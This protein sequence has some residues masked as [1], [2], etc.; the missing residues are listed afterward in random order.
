LK[1]TEAHKRGK[2]G[3]GF[4]PEKDLVHTTTEL[5][6][7]NRKRDIVDKDMYL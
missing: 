5:R 4:I 2:D 6:L 3:L 1:E 7:H